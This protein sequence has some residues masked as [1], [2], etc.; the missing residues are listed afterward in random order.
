MRLLP[1]G[2]AYV[3]TMMKTPSITSR[4]I[5]AAI[6]HHLTT[7]ISTMKTFQIVTL[8]AMIAASMAF[9]PNAPKGEYFMPV[10]R[11]KME[12]TV[13]HKIVIGT[14]N[15]LW[16]FPITSLK[17]LSKNFSTCAINI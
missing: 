2:A 1:A 11:R 14:A 4:T 6:Y 3:L 9:A 10:L 5:I 13:L 7:N 8:F 17:A 16:I 12:K 15:W